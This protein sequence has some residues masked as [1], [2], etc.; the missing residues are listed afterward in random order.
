MAGGIFYP[1]GKI[2][3]EGNTDKNWRQLG[4]F[5]GNAT[6]GVKDGAK[7]RGKSSPDIIL[8]TQEGGKYD[9]CQWFFSNLRDRSSFNDYDI[10]GYVVLVTLQC[11]LRDHWIPLYSKC[12]FVGF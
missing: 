5:L 1:Y 6:Q 12:L 8:H 10:I 9:L 2:W 11:M 3:A 7:S 4:W